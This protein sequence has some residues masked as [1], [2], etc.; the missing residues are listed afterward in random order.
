M[1]ISCPECRSVFRVDPAKVPQAGVRAR[2]SVCGGVMAIGAGGVIDDD[3]VGAGAFA[4]AG[5]ATPG[6]GPTTVGGP[7]RV[8]AAPARTQPLAAQPPSP[9]G[10]PAAS[11]LGSPGRPPAG[12]L[13]R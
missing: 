4:H 8:A 7:A 2:C 3:F 9:G 1:N 10:W 11:G 5:A 13:G 6:T 12:K